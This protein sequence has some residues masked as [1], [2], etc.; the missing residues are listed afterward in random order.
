MKPADVKYLLS[1]VK[2]G[3]FSVTLPADYFE[4]VDGTASTLNVIAAPKT[5][6]AK[7]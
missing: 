7:V 6:S 2:D 3:L 5:T 1:A 4:S